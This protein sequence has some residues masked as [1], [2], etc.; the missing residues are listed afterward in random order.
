MTAEMLS[1]DGLTRK[2]KKYA[3]EYLAGKQIK[4]T[5]DRSVPALHRPHRPESGL[6]K[7][8]DF[9]RRRAYCREI[10]RATLTS[11]MPAYASARAL[12]FKKTYPPLRGAISPLGMTLSKLI[13][14]MNRVGT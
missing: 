9:G 5:C 4:E 14:R 13:S 6:Q 11:A 8:Q 2:G 10:R 1:Y 3:Q 12:A 7:A